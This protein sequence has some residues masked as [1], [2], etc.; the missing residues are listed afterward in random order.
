MP[1]TFVFLMSLIAVDTA[2]ASAASAALATLVS[3]ASVGASWFPI[4]SSG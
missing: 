3:A 1:E 4:C 2:A